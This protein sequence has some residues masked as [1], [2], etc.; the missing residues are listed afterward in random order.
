MFF[1]FL[2]TA[3]LHKWNIAKRPIWLLVFRVCQQ[4]APGRL[5]YC[6]PRMGGV[7]VWWCFLPP[8]LW[9]AGFHDSGENCSLLVFPDQKNNADNATADRSPIYSPGWL[10]LPV[11]TCMLPEDVALV[12][13]TACRRERKDTKVIFLLKIIR[14][15]HMERHFIWYF[16]SE[17]D[18]NIFH[19]WGREVQD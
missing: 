5:H 3:G 14:P 13:L 16:L 12:C 2:L 1:I 15:V 9:S 18:R 17:W 19:Y 4:D 11:P 6:L 7:T 8:Q 10:I